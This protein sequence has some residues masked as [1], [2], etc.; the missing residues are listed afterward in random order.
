MPEFDLPGHTLSV[1]AAHPELSCRGTELKVGT[2]QG[3]FDDILCAGNDDALQLVFDVLGEMAE[4]F[5]GRNFH[6]GGDEAPKKRWE[7]CPKCQAR[8]KELGLQNEEELQG[9]FVNRAIDFLRQRGKTAVVW[10]ESLNSGMMPKDCVAQRWMDKKNRAAEFANNGGKV[11]VSDFYFYYCDY[12]YGM[13]PLKKTYNYNPYFKGLSK[14]GK[15]NIIGVET[16]IWTEYIRDFDKLCYMCFPRFSAVA[17]TG[18]SLAENRN[19][20]SFMHRFENLAQMLTDIGV[21]PAPAK[22]WNPNPIRR[23]IELKQFF[24]GTF[25]W[26]TVK[27]SFSS[28]NA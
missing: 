7:Q 17:E 25:N 16:P 19:L 1:L 8:M 9:W 3:I 21:N 10:N 14:E 18:W 15:N 4:L 22:N 28:T 23:L 24:K 11:I 2:K 12:P 13:T 27:N 6:I 26:E 20:K 5:P